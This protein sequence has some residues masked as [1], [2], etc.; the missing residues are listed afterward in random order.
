M[1]I[2]LKP[3]QVKKQS[4]FIKENDIDCMILDIG[5]PDMT[6]Y[7]VIQALKKIKNKKTPPI[8]VYTGKDLDT[9][10]TQDLQKYAKSI[11]IKGVKSEERLLDETSMFLHRTISNLPQSKQEIIK[12]LY[13][14][15]L[16]LMIK[17]FLW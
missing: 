11:I 2:V 16:F 10:E 12:K 17:R 7:E 15:D 14:K 3:K 1:S 13:N 5:L 9:T 4:Q 6:G 8:I